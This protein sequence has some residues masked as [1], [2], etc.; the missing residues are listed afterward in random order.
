MPKAQTLIA[1]QLELTPVVSDSEEV[2]SALAA[3]RDLE[4][5][6]SRRSQLGDFRFGHLSLQN[7]VLDMVTFSSP[8]S[9]IL[10]SRVWGK[11]RI[12]FSILLETSADEP[13]TPK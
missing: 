10:G 13:S 12:N 9:I 6:A 3:W 5:N 2:R 4:S 7:V 1:R 8:R 11:L